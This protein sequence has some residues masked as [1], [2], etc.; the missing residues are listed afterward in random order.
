[1]MMEVDPLFEDLYRRQ[2]GGK[3]WTGWVEGSQPVYAKMRYR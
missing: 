2:Q 1:M 3:R